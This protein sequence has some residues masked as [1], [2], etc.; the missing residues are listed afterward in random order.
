ML[1]SST[2][3]DVDWVSHI[4]WHNQDIGEDY[5]IPLADEALT[6]VCFMLCSRCRHKADELYKSNEVKP[7]SSYLVVGSSWDDMAHYLA[8]YCRK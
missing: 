2:V 1:S 3:E 6:Q 7:G 8:T 4:V 5:P